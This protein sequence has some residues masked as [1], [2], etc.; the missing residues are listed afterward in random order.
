MY[1]T[2]NYILNIMRIKYLGRLLCPNWIHLSILVN[3]SHIFSSL[4]NINKDLSALFKAFPYIF[5]LVWAI[6]LNNYLLIASYVSESE[7]N[8]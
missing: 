7:I 2:N 5:I 3:K 4:E 1:G 8:Q 6:S